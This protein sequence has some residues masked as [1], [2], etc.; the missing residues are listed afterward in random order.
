MVLI[1]H[2][3]VTEKDDKII[4]RERN[5]IENTTNLLE[6]DRVFIKTKKFERMELNEFVVKIGK[7][8]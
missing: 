3:D 8:R 7:R 6:D 4:K 1:K 2:I 5:S